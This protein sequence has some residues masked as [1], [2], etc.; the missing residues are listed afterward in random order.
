MLG[1]VAGAGGDLIGQE[2]TN[3]NHNRSLRCVNV[4]EVLGSGVGGALGGAAGWGLGASAKAAGLADTW[5]FN[6]A[7][8][9]LSGVPGYVGTVL[10]GSYGEDGPGGDKGMSGRKDPPDPNGCG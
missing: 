5:G 4:P 6:W 2:I 1:G 10:G 9:F 7:N 3:L 8:Q